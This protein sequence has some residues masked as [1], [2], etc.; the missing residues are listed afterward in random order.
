MQNKECNYYYL[1][2]AVIIALRPKLMNKAE[3]HSRVR[4]PLTQY[5]AL[6]GTLP[7]YQGRKACWGNEGVVETVAG[8]RYQIKNIAEANQVPYM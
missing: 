8:D 6:C 1:L 5:H 3:M 2:C 4:I 7:A